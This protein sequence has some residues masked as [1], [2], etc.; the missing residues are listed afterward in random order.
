MERLAAA[1]T[2]FSDRR[3][4]KTASPDDLQLFRRQVLAMHSDLMLEEQL[5]RRLIE[6]YNATLQAR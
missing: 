4:P 5:G 6:I 2:M 3:D 1:A